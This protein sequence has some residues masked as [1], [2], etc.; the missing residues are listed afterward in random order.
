LDEAA[1]QVKRALELKAADVEATVLQA[2]IDDEQRKR[3]PAKLAAVGT[4]PVNSEKAPSG[5]KAAFTNDIGMEFVWISGVPGGGAFV[6]KCEVT[7]KQF[8]A[9][10]SKLPDGQFVPG[11]DLP[12]ANVS[13]EEATRF[14]ERLTQNGK[15]CT[16]PS[17]AEWLTAAGLAPEQGANAWE[18]LQTQG[19]LAKEVTSLNAKPSLE[20]PAVVGSRG[21]QPN[22]LCDLF[23]NLR[24][25]VIDVGADGKLSGKSAGFSFTS[26]GRTKA[27][28]PVQQVDWMKQETGFRCILREGQS[29]LNR[30]ESSPVHI[31][32][33]LQEE[34]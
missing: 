24:E 6:G 4:A 11:D 23:G 16:L 19:A 8:R 30:M 33:H 34:T 2:Q 17:K 5:K 15:R 22:G 10:M 7:Q 14:C 32:S 12:V 27:L 25:W 31:S 13:W 26:S 1:R 21:P 3:A 29:L 9:V 18:I 28:I 20:K